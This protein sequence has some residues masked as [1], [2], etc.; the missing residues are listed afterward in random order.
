MSKTSNGYATT[1]DGYVTPNASLFWNPGNP[2][3]HWGF[4]GLSGMDGK[5]YLHYPEMNFYVNE[6]G[7]IRAFGHESIPI[8]SKHGKNYIEIMAPSGKESSS[9]NT[10]NNGIHT[11]QNYARIP[12]GETKLYIPPEPIDT[13][14]VST[15]I[16]ILRSD[17]KSTIKSNPIDQQKPVPVPQELR[18]GLTKVVDGKTYYEFNGPVKLIREW[19]KEL[20]RT[21]KDDETVY[22]DEDLTSKSTTSTRPS[23]I[24]DNK[25]ISKTKSF[26]QDTLDKI[27]KI[28]NKDSNSNP[29][30]LSDKGVYLYKYPHNQVN[31]YQVSP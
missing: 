27:K 7:T 31:L 9:W 28:L 4:E 12:V 22:E 17:L 5:R 14:S 29:T 24:M 15:K 30:L 10:G 11:V 6:D 23:I 8:I 25:I 18:E 2:N 21:E 13:N 20:S 19:I 3:L 16:P 1:K 26:T